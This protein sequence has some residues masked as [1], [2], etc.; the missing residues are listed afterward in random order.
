MSSSIR[1]EWREAIR[2]S[3]LDPSAKLLAQ[4]L[5]TYMDA[6]GECWPSKQT[7]SGDCS[8]D[9]RVVDRA[10]L[11][12]ESAGFIHV[13]RSKGRK[14]NRYSA[15]VPNPVH[16]DGV[17]PVPSAGVRESQPRRNPGADALPTPAQMGYEP[18][19]LNQEP[20]NPVIRGGRQEKRA[21][22]SGT[23]TSRPRGWIDNLSSYTGCRAIRGDY[24]FGHKYDPLGTDRPPMDWPHP[25][26]TPHEIGTALDEIERLA[27]LA[28]GIQT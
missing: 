28:R 16:T 13:E 7:L 22:R 17:N 11:R 21:G 5:S 1:N 2:A 19:V 18:E 3:R 15:I 26:P 8:Q 4:T 20:S 24:G 6:K 12:L 10:M 25:R 23:R 9:I 14:P 27:V